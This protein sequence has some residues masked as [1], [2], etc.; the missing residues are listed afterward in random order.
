MVNLQKYT[1][2]WHEIASFPAWFQKGCTNT[3]AQYTQK[4]DYIEV[5]NSC[6][7]NGK[8]SQRIGKAF[9]TDDPDL[10]KVQFF[11]PFKADYRIEYVDPSYQYAIV[12]TKRKYLWFLS[13][14]KSVSPQQ[15]TKLSKIAKQKG[16]DVSR[17]QFTSK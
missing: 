9:P 12:G 4:D 10:L 5:K 6:M 7:K 3:V 17:L 1:G 2:T 13:R 15:I 16:F 11:F 8:L 14:K